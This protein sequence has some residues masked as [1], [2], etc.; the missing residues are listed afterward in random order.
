[1][2]EEI[3]REWFVRMRFPGY[4]ETKFEKGLPVG[5]EITRLDEILEL[6][7]GKSLKSEERIE[8]EFPVY[9]S[10]GIVGTHNK[11]LV[12]NAGII[13]GRKGNVGS[14]HWSDKPFFPIDTVYFV[15]S[16]ISNYFLFYLLKSL[17]FI[18][19]DAAVPGLNRN[20]AYSNK[21]FFP[22]EELINAFSEKAEKI[23]TMKAT[24]NRK[25]EILE[26]TRDMLLSRLISGKLPVEN[27]DIQFPPSMREE[28]MKA[29]MVAE[30]RTK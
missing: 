16:S 6:S 10:S 5:W 24:L 22:K 13:V 28:E 20:Q 26:N 19:N 29:E 7:Y 14:V 2:A 18:N 11:S 27:L 23:F 21:F 25:T 12:K 4:K 1:M 30:A 9:G 17:N 3:Y 15:K 8:G